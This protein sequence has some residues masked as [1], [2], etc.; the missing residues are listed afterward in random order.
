SGER[1]WGLSPGTKRFHCAA[2][3]GPRSGERGWPPTPA[4]PLR[5][6]SLQR[7]R[8]PESADGG[9][10]VTLVAGQQLAST[11]PRSGERGWPLRTKLPT[12]CTLL[13]RGRAPESAD[14]RRRSCV[15]STP[16]WLQ[17]GRAPESADGGHT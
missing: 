10:G 12:P 13:Q 16:A 6:P 1:G 2:S 5:T 14:G 7:G 9:S 3:T 17:R 15:R 11:G 8:A 4:K